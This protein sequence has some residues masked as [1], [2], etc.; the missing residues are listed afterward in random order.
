MRFGIKI[1]RGGSVRVKNVVIM[2]GGDTA[3]EKRR[4]SRKYI[5]PGLNGAENMES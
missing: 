4:K 2:A 5:R 1:G 3:H